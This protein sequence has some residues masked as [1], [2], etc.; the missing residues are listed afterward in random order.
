[1]SITNR[2][3]T[4]FKKIEDIEMKNYQLTSLLFCVVIFLFGVFTKPEC[5]SSPSDSSQGSTACSYD[6]VDLATTGGGL[7]TSALYVLLIETYV[8]NRIKEKQVELSQNHID[9]ERESKEKGR[10]NRELEFLHVFSEA[11]RGAKTGHKKPQELPIRGLCS[12]VQEFDDGRLLNKKVKQFIEE[13]SI[14]E[15]AAQLIIQGFTPEKDNILHKAIVETCNYALGFSDY[16]AH[17]CAYGF[18]DDLKAYIRAW[19][20]C[21]LRWGVEIPIISFVQGSLGNECKGKYKERES[22]IKA[23]SYLIEKIFEYDE[24]KEYL[25]SNERIRLVIIEYLRKLIKIFQADMNN[26]SKELSGLS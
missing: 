18:Y 6:V 20:V 15:E 17:G 21:S 16:K 23:I 7:V 19:L 24:I 26:V 3:K 2:V 12:Q 5:E 4:I 10:K 14:R 8:K 11:T 13:K 9:N 22:Y 1:M 25:N